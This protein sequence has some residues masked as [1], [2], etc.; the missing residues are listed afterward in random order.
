MR[1]SFR[2]FVFARG[3]N[4]AQRALR[5]QLAPAS[6]RREKWRADRRAS[7]AIPLAAGPLPLSRR[8]GSSTSVCRCSGGRCLTASCTWSSV[9]VF[10]RFEPLQSSIRTNAQ[11]QRDAGSQAIGWSPACGYHT[12]RVAILSYTASSAARLAFPCASVGK[13][14]GKVFKM[15]A[16]SARVRP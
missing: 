3:A 1:T 4:E 8:A 11:L 7:A 14:S 2:I 12:I 5:R 16:N 10:I 6:S 9:A 13:T 15:W